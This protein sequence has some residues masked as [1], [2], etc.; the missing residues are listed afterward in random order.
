MR[1]PVF[2]YPQHDDSGGVGLYS[3][4]EDV[5]L[6]AEAATG[7]G[8]IAMAYFR[9]STLK[10]WDK[11]KGHAVTEADMAVNDHLE[12]VL[13][14]Q[15]PDYGWLSEESALAKSNRN[16]KRNFIV[17][18]ID[19]TTSFIKHRADWCIAVA[20]EED[21]EVIAAA[22]HVP[23]PKITFRAGKGIG[24]YREGVKL[25]CSP[26][27]GA[28]QPALRIMSKVKDF[29]AVAIADKLHIKNRPYALIMRFI[30]VAEG[31]ADALLASGYKSDWDIAAGA[32]IVSEA[33]GKVSTMTG[34]PLSFNRVQ[35]V[36]YSVIAANSV[37]YDRLINI[38]T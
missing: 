3:I 9:K 5:A 22:V 36:Q 16:G 26:D 4:A 27:L 23:V 6:L 1:R 21:G 12:R 25:F 13:R 24:A 7:A 2:A 32:L 35:P 19:G 20:L 8:D 33:G 17:D 14:A 28:N 18:P 37:C 15:R 38:P 11:T 30:M 31:D 29:E 34:K 10:K